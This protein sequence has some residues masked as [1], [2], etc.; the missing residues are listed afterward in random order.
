[1]GSSTVHAQVLRS[2]LATRKKVVSSTSDH[3][4][5][6]LKW[7]V[8]NNLKMSSVPQPRL[9]HIK[10][11]SHFDGYGFT[12]HSE[13]NS[14]W[15][16]VGKIDEESPAEAGGLKPNDKIIEID[17]ANVTRENH[18]QVIQ[19][20]KA[21][22]DETK[23]LVAD[24][25]CEDYHK[26]KGVVITSSLPYTLHLSSEGRNETSSESEEEDDS[27]GYENNTVHGDVMDDKPKESTYSPSP[28]DS[29]SDE[30]NPIPRRNPVTPYQ[31]QRSSYNKNE[32]V[33]G[34]HLNMTA[35]KMRQR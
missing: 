25:E 12:L 17:G 29:S 5:S 7:S 10:K 15:Q 16:I 26:E 9:C 31:P 2:H 6:M 27:M 1:M 32:L 34:L 14:G 4:Q 20:I 3:T 21:G 24:R 33:A 8:H 18:K 23:L 22:G 28:S 19:R 30:E 11:W 13:K 35:K